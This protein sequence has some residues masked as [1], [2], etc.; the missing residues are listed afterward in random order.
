MKHLTITRSIRA[1][2]LVAVSIAY[3]ISTAML[4]ILGIF[5]TRQIIA[6]ENEKAYTNQ[7]TV[8][9]RTLQKKQDKL[10]ASGMESLFADGYKNNAAREL[11]ELHYT[12]N[13]KIYP[14]I[15]D[16]TGRIVLHP[17]LEPGSTEIAN[18]GFV[19]KMLAMQNGSQT[20][21][22]GGDEK[23]MLFRTFDPW[24][25]TIGYAIKIKDKY[26]GVSKTVKGISVIMVLSSLMGLAIVYAML[27][28]VVKPIKILAKDAGIIGDGQYGHQVTVVKSR[29]EVAQL[30][31]SLASMATNIRDRDRQI[32]KFNEQLE[33][34]VQERT[35][36]L[37]TSQQELKKAMQAAEAAT[38][39][40][41]E[42]L[43]NMSH[44]I[45]TPMNGIIGMTGLL[46]KTKLDSEQRDFVQV[47]QGSAEALLTIINDILDFSKIEA[48]KLDFDILN[49]DLH[50]TMEGVTEMLALKAHEKGLEFGIVIEPAVPQYLVGDPSRLRQV[51]IN[52]AANA[53]K[54]TRQGDVTIRV[55]NINETHTQ[56]YLRF[57]VT[58]T[59]IGIPE[60]RRD[61]LF[62]PFSQVD[63]STTRT[64]GGT[65]LGLAV[66]KK[67][68]ELMQGLISVE[69]TEGQ[70]STFWFTAMFEKQPDIRVQKPAVPA[71]IEGKR[72]LAVDDSATNLEILSA[73]L[74]PWQCELS[75]AAS[76]PEALQLMKWAIKNHAA[77]DL[78]IIDHMM[79]GMGGEELARRI[80]ADPDLSDTRL[81]MLTS[82]GLGGDAAMAKRLGYD[83][84]LTKPIKRKDLLACI[85]EVIGRGAPATETG[86]QDDPA[87]R[88]GLEKPPRIDAR[89]LLAEDNS[90]NRKVALNILS[91][92]G[93][94]ADAVS[95]GEE[96]VE[97]FKTAEYDM[98]LMDV[99]MPVMDGISAAKKIR[100][101]ERKLNLEKKKKNRRITIVAMTASA[102]K[103]DRQICLDAGMDDYL[104][105]PVS[106][107]ALQDKIR[108]WLP[109][110]N[111][112]LE[113]FQQDPVGPSS[114][115]GPI[116][117]ANPAY[118]L[119]S[120]LSRVMGDVSFL[121]MMLTEF[122]CKK[123]H[124]LRQCAAAIAARDPAG[125][126]SQAHGLKGVSA[127]LGLNQI[128][129]TAQVLEQIGHQRNL[130]SAPILM[131]KLEE[132]YRQLEGYLDG[133]DWNSLEEGLN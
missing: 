28:R 32:R 11:G 77:Y 71:D 33:T 75:T 29:D 111:R 124:Y 13:L 26:A 69:S 86:T 63:A 116:I 67:L 103:G 106:L 113:T 114:S 127:N 87:L 51:L 68:V 85:L 47:I 35:A 65:G 89:I 6:S 50:E 102:M 98:I 133:L 129:E 121:K 15:I 131:E 117:G 119:K 36:A 78:A 27:N 39:A 57:A 61:R 91:K 4:L 92:F 60:E 70:G 53:I 82:R 107:D 132:H 7:L 22:W 52:L 31:A 84:Y 20:Y 21:T 122:R 42:F 58:D 46:A 48:G 112:T 109:V 14:F 54:F 40:K 55:S 123:E 97:A 74:K 30:A 88:G 5:I 66:S 130:S 2:L 128:S 99:Q 104:A 108:K 81:I 44:E 9:L 64:Y 126:A 38:T 24:Q 25:W 59:G 18:E 83:A 80:K 93:F 1:K 19:R 16:A 101:I 37:E 45:R 12:K 56:A 105:K 72:V 49:F 17:T 115:S 94:R 125:L 3:I 110:G 23:W 41:S 79:P 62:K 43:A 90:I 76:A 96:A 10:L 118:D 95:N 100:A 8:I 73:Y 34:R 120:A